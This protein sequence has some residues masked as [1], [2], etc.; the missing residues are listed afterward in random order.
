MVLLATLVGQV[1]LRI[2][3]VQRHIFI[4]LSTNDHFLIKAKGWIQLVADRHRVDDRVGVSPSQLLPSSVSPTCG[5][6]A[7]LWSDVLKARRLLL[8]GLGAEH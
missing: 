2:I 4:L 5:F 7:L 3:G 8:G 1:G 6:K